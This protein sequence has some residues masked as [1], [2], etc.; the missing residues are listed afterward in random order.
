MEAEALIGHCIADIVKGKPTMEWGSM[1]PRA[2]SKTAMRDLASNFRLNGIRRVDPE[3]VIRIPVIIGKEIKPEAVSTLAEWK[4]PLK[5]VTAGIRQPSLPQLETFVAKGTTQL[6][7]FGGQH[8]AAALDFTLQEAHARQRAS[9]RTI[10]RLRKDRA[11]LTETLETQE[12]ETDSLKSEDMPAR[13]Q[14]KNTEQQLEEHEAHHRAD[15]ELVID[16]G[17]W[18]VALYNYGE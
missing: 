10:G 2:L 14:L 6:K 9:A 5:L 13:Q 12:S 3:T 15:I 17:K 4:D 7:P 16:E 8:R 18:M 11:R 1:N